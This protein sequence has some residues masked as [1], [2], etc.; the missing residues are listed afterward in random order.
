MLERCEQLVAARVA[1]A[2]DEERI[3][4]VAA[5]DALVAEATTRAR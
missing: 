1:Q 4:I 5:A 3:R 2:T